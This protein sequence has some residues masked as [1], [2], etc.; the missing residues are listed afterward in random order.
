MKYLI[1][2]LKEKNGSAT[3]NTGVKIIIAVVLG[4]VLIAGLFLL[5]KGENGVFNKVDDKVQVMMNVDN[6]PISFAYDNTTRKPSSLKFTYDGTHW[7]NSDVP[8]FGEN[9][10][11]V[12]YYSNANA[13]AAVV[14]VEDTDGSAVL[15]SLD[16]GATFKEV[17][18]FGVHDKEKYDVSYSVYYSESQGYSVS[19]I[20][21]FKPAYKAEYGYSGWTYVFYSTDGVHWQQDMPWY[22]F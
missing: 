8:T 17:K 7:I 13:P 9:A 3:I 1:N 4:G 6:E 21:R 19:K 14:I 18:R 15:T 20:A 10:K 2:K 12:K 22:M 16:K 5:F 11:I